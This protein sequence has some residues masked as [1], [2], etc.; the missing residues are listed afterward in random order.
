MER[1][2]DRVKGGLTNRGIEMEGEKEREILLNMERDRET[3]APP[4]EHD[5]CSMS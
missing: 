4:L 1:D 5:C 3:E 2:R